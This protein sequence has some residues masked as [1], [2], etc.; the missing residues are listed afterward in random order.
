MVKM[1]TLK[2]MFT[3]VQIMRPFWTKRLSCVLKHYQTRAMD[4]EDFSIISSSLLH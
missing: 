2:D 4:D 3:A 1:L